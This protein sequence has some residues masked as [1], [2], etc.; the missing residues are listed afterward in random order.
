MQQLIEEIKKEVINHLDI[1][2]EYEDEE[3]VEIIDDIIIT[4]SKSRYVSIEDK[5]HIHYRDND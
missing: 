5:R 1:Y 2:R 3:I 4:R